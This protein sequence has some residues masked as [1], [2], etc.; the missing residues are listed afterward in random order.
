[1]KRTNPRP[2]DGPAKRSI[3]IV[4]CGN[5]LAADDG[6]GGKIIDRLKRL[7]L[8]EAEMV[9]LGVDALRLLDYLRGQDKLIVVDAVSSP[10]HQ[11]GTVL[12]GRFKGAETLPSLSLHHFGPAE[13]LELG[14][15][16]YP[17]RM[18]R[19]TVVESVVVGDV[20][21][22]RMEPTRAVQKA[23]DR[24]VHIIKE[25]VDSFSSDL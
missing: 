11:P 2:G 12:R 16:L 9:D 1:M 5:V 3:T 24:A 18:P 22:G 19:E 23:I 25:E 8:P 17:E 10:A 14:R 20:T 6:V 21:P 15:T 7:S 13:V 4:G